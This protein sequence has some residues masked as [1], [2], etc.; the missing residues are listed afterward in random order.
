[1]ILD[2]RER[3]EITSEEQ[4][5]V[6]N[7]F[8]VEEVKCSLPLL[9]DEVNLK[10]LDL[11][12][13]SMLRHVGLSEK[14]AKK[15]YKNFREE[16]INNTPI[17]IWVIGRLLTW[18]SKSNI[19]SDM[20]ESGDHQDLAIALETI[21]IKKGFIIMDPAKIF[22]H[23][24]VNEAI[25]IYHLGELYNK[26][27]YLLE[28]FFKDS[29]QKLFLNIIDIPTPKDEDNEKHIFIHRSLEDLARDIVLEHP[30]LIEDYIEE[31]IDEYVREKF[32]EHF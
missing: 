24:N 8:G 6:Y 3:Y 7:K 19:V 2:P 15:Y 26:N 14:I 22:K 21:S 32:Q 23:P 13:Y 31:R 4:V 27:Y 10:G 29:W 18:L 28:I 20:I 1:M 5:T 17:T 9:R 12:A 11:V 25:K 30:D 16:V